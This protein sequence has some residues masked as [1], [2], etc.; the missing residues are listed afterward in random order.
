MKLKENAVYTKKELL[1]AIENEGLENVF[2]DEPGFPWS[3][4]QIKEFNHYKEL[5]FY[6]DIEIGKGCTCYVIN[7]ERTFTNE[8]SWLRIRI[9]KGIA[10]FFYYVQVMKLKL[11]RLIQDFLS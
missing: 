5:F 4:Q 2:E 11:Q 7:G 8:L 6:V 3:R 1:D 9:T 10:Y